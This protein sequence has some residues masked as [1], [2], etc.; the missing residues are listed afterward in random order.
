[1]RRA[2]ELQQSSAAC[3]SA[4]EQ[5][6]FL[7][8][9]SYLIKLSLSKSSRCGSE[10]TAAA[11]DP[12]QPQLSCCCTG[13]ARTEI[14]EVGRGL[15]LADTQT[16]RYGRLHSRRRLCARRSSRRRALHWILARPPSRCSSNLLPEH[17]SPYKSLVPIPV[18]VPRAS[19]YSGGVLARALPEGL[20]YL[21]T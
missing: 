5:E 17:N 15:S 16:G 7:Q 14:R 6:I 12:L 18:P 10:L 9:L 4:I 3:Y 19:A 20:R 2:R 21:S 8:C 1:M 11:Q 13:S